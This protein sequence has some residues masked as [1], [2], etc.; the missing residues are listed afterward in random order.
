MLADLEEDIRRDPEDRVTST[1]PDV[2]G[3]PARSFA[4]FV[5]AHWDALTA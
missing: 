4:D 5:T 2:T 3:R 1:I